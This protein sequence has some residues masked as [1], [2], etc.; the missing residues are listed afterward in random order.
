MVE[1]IVKRRAITIRLRAGCCRAAAIQTRTLL[2]GALVTGPIVAGTIVAG[3]IVAVLVVAGA[4]IALIAVIAR[5]SIVISAFG[6]RFAVLTRLVVAGLIVTRTVVAVL[7]VAGT[8]L[9]LRPVVAILAWL[10]IRTIVLAV[11]LAGLLL[12]GR[13]EII[14]L[15]DIIAFTVE[16]LVLI[17]AVLLARTIRVGFFIPRATFGEHAEIMVGEL[18]II[19][20]EHAVAG[21]LRVARKRF[22]FFEQLRGIAARAIVDAVAHFGPSVLLTLAI[23]AAPAATA[24]GLLTIVDQADAVLNKG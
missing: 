13:V 16:A 12:A 6:T 9:S 3:T 8:I 5:R 22:V 23:L 4:V 21:L 20:G 15:T 17:V 10:L 7:I 2:A 11:I 14:A 1:I 24:T 19:F 18:E